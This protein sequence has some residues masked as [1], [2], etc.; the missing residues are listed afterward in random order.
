MK[1]AIAYDKE[2]DTV[3]EKFENTQYFKL[4]EIDSGTIDYTEIVGT[5]GKNTDELADLLLFLEDD[6][7]ICCDI[8]E[9]S[10]E[11]ISDEGIIIYKNCHGTSESV[12]QNFLN[13]KLLYN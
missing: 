5:M 3:F 1:L 2:T 10:A 11:Q 12:F 9:Q 4:Y 8:T 6:V 7:L 13:G